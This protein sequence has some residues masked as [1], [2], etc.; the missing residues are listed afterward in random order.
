MKTA[1]ET[2][3]AKVDDNAHTRVHD[4]VGT[5]FTFPMYG[6]QPGY[7]PSIG[8]HS[9]AEHTSLAFPVTSNVLPIKEAKDKLEVLEGRLRAIEG[10]ESYGFSDVARLSLALGVT[11][12][13]KFKVPEFEK[14]KGNTCPKNHL[15][16]SCRKMAAYAYDDKLLIHFFQDSLAEAA[17]SWYTHMESSHIYS[18][19]DLADAFVRQYKYNMH[20]ALDMLQLHHMAKK[21]DESFKEYV[22]RW[23]ELAAQVEPPLYDKEMVA[24]FV[25]T[26]QPPFYEHMIGNMTSNFADIIIIG[27]RI[28]IG[29]KNGKITSQATTPKKSIFNP[30]KEKEGGV[31]ATSTIPIWEGHVPTHIYQPSL[32]YPPYVNNTVSGPQTISQPP[33]YYQPQQANAG[34]LEPV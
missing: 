25:S 20:V 34:A 9:E 3:F 7:T 30:E 10:F 18:W 23:R 6:L 1:G 24:M 31:H 17:L 11:I 12:P 33:G 21:D 19:T 13:H 2:S 16:M 5:Q 29:L 15:T 4:A 8:D 14:Y 22:Q 32:S 28:E 26:L 27:E